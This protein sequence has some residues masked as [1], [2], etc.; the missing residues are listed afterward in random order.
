VLFVAKSYLPFVPVPL[1]FGCGSQFW[2]ETNTQTAAHPKMR[3]CLFDFPNQPAG[4]LPG[5]PVIHPGNPG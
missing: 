5:R 2:I 1:R 4:P 3:G